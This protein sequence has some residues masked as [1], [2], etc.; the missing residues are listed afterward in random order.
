MHSVQKR[1]P[2]NKQGRAE[3]PEGSALPSKE[4]TTSETERSRGCS[5]GRPRRP[6]GPALYFVG[7]LGDLP[8]VPVYV[9][10]YGCTPAF[11]LPLRGSLHPSRALTHSQRPPVTLLWAQVGKSPNL[12][13]GLGSARLFLSTPT[14]KCPEMT[15]Q[16]GKRKL[17]TSH[18][19][20]SMPKV[21]QCSR[22]SKQAKVNLD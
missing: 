11:G 1:T 12:L 7:G 4:A 5:A 14:S 17:A 13:S 22:A 16:S 2:E 19:G 3:Q 9:V 21:W 10:K 18:T 20:F 8:E 15:L 6:P